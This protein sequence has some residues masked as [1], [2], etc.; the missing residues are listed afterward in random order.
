M[1]ILSGGSKLQISRSQLSDSGTYTCVASNVEGKARK[2]YHL[3]IHGTEYL[4]NK[5]AFSHFLVRPIYRPY[6]VLQS[7]QTS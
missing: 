7:R 5:H 1:H 2:N 6:C 3:V 4:E